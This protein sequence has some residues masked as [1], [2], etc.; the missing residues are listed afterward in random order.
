MKRLIAKKEMNLLKGSETT[1]KHK[2]LM[3]ILNGKEKLIVEKFEDLDEEKKDFFINK[4]HL[5]FE[6]AKNEWIIIEDGIEYIEQK[7]RCQYCNKSTR[8]TVVIKNKYNGNV[9]V[10]GPTCVLEFPNDEGIN[11]AKILAESKKAKT[12]ESINIA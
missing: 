11:V 1:K 9:L 7:K 2:I 8:N 10:V 12:L 4:Y 5:I 6:E 3:D